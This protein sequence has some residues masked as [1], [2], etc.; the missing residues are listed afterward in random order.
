M[1]EGVDS[2]V[3][4][5]CSLASDES[6]DVR[7]R[8]TARKLCSNLHLMFES[9]YC[10]SLLRWTGDAGP[11]RRVLLLRNDTDTRDTPKNQPQLESI[12]ITQRSRQR[13]TPHFFAVV[14]LQVQY[15]IPRNSIL[16]RQA[17]DPK[18]ELGRVRS[19]HTTPPRVPP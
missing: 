10:S 16:I 2:F 3:W 18:W 4:P 11:F 6:C 9:Q 7:A 13:A 19:I 5:A 17:H 15:H 1:V 8:E 14:V 12:A